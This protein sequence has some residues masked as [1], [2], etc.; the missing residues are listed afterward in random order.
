VAAGEDGVHIHAV[1]GKAE[2]A[3]D[4]FDGEAFAAAGD[5]HEEDAFGDDFRVDFVAEFKE[6]LAF[7]EPFLRPS[8]PPISLTLVGV[9]RN[10]MTPLRLTRRRFSSRRAGREA[11]ERVGWRARARA[12]GEA[13][14]VEGEAF[15]GAGELREQG[16]GSGGVFVVEEGGEF[17]F[18]GGR[19]ST[20]TRLRS[21]SSGMARTGE[22]MTVNFSAVEAGGFDVAEAAAAD[23]G[24]VAEGFVEVFE[25]EDGGVGVEDEEV[26][27]RRGG[28]WCRGWVRRRRFG[29]RR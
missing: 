9:E 11:G 21:S 26:E 12:E 6:A 29:G 7:E 15:E 20:K 22:V 23:G 5:A 17:D 24:G 18:V 14:F 25:V 2:A 28:R 1:E 16:G 27:G 10:S 3:G 13:G 8:R 4:G 19:S